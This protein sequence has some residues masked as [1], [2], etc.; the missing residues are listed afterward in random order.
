MRCA[1][2]VVGDPP[3]TLDNT[4]FIAMA[5]WRLGHHDEARKWFQQ[6]VDWQEKKNVTDDELPR[7]RV[8][9]EGPLK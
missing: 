1:L 6:A 3:A 2:K 4:L 8:E 5:H 7:F 9:A